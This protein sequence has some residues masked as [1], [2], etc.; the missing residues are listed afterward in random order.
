MSFQK[1]ASSVDFS[2]PISQ[3]MFEQFRKRAKNKF[4]CRHGCVTPSGSIKFCNTKEALTKHYCDPKN[5]HSF[6]EYKEWLAMENEV[7]EAS[8]M[9]ICHEVSGIQGPLVRTRSNDSTLSGMMENED[10]LE[11]EIYQLTLQ[12]QRLMI[13]KSEFANRSNNPVKP[14]KVLKVVDSDDDIDV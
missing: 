13:R 9:E 11:S 14:K 2:K 8:A 6:Q 5:G 12:T 10:E 1:K 3:Q 7:D 4:E